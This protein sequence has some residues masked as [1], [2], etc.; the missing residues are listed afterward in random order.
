VRLLLPFLV[1]GLV[2]PDADMVG[3][4]LQFDPVPDARRLVIAR[5]S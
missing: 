2:R 1:G 3:L 5:G 4:L